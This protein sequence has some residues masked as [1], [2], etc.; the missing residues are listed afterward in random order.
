MCCK[1]ADYTTALT[2]NC[3]KTLVMLMQKVLSINNVK[4]GQNVSLSNTDYKKNLESNFYF[5]LSYFVK[6]YII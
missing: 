6:Q 3:C 5:I 4:M 2:A 1:S